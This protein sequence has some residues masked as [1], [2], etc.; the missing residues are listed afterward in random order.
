MDISDTPKT[1]P[2]KNLRYQI[3]LRDKVLHNAARVHKHIFDG[4]AHR[5]GVDGDVAVN[6]LARDAKGFFAHQFHRLS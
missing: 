6:Q 4:R 2:L 5:V 1:I 3:I